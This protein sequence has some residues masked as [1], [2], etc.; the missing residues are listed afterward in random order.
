[1]KALYGFIVPLLLLFAAI[2][3]RVNDPAQVQQVR[4][5]VFDSYQRLDPRPYDPSLPVRI[6]D[7]DEESLD[8]FGQWPWSRAQ[9][10]LILDRLRELGAATVAIDVMMVEPDRT[11]PRA[12]A[13][14]LPQT[15]DFESARLLMGTLPDPDQQ[16]AEAMTRIPTILPFAMVWEDPRRLQARPASKAGFVYQ[17]NDET[18]DPERYMQ[19]LPYW[20]TSL[21]ILQE[22]AAGVGSVNTNPDNDGVTRHVPLFM[23]VP[24]LKPHPS[25][26]N[27][28]WYWRELP[29]RGSLAMEALR[30]AQGGTTYQI[31]MSGAN[32]ED[33]FGSD[34]GIAKVRVG[35]ITAPTASDG[36]LL[37]YD[38]GHKAERFFSLAD[39][40]DVDFDATQVTGRIIFI[41][42]SVQGLRDQ[43]PT[44]LDPVMAGVEIHA[45]IA[46]QLMAGQ[47]L[48]RPYWADVAEEATLVTFGLILIFLA[49]GRAAL[50]GLIVAT[51]AIVGSFGSSY[52]L[53]KSR[54][55]LLDP[56]YPAGI[57]FFIF[58]AATLIGFIRTER[59]KAHVR[60]AF[61]RY[62]SPILVDQLS[63]N[64]EK[65]KLGGELRELTVMFSDIRGFTKL[66]EGLD[67]Q[68]LTT[69]INSFLTPMTRVI[70]NRQG[71][72]DKYIGDCIMAFWNA[73]IDVEP[74]GRMAILA[75]YDMRAELVRI[76]Q[77]FA[78]EAAR[79]GDKLIEIRIGMG[80]NS[81]ICCVGNMGSDQRFDYSVLGDTVNTASRLESLSPAYFVDLVIGEETALTVPDFALLELDQVRVKG[82]N[83]PVRIYTGLG[84]ERVAK[85]NSFQALKGVHDAMLAAYRGQAWSA[86]RASLALAREAAPETLAKFYDMYEV[87]I[88]EYVAVP[89]PEDWDG[90]YVATTKGG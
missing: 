30:V 52:Y 5:L 80:L 71:T 4:N 36:S 74:H 2:V 37:L 33:F 42:T 84:D 66:S 47:Y 14:N 72:I 7:I 13:R 44:P 76:N 18:G 12:I 85:S 77:R 89:P 28:P 31:K 59:E 73:P 56:L 38:S 45:Q 64:P 82:K 55:F 8:K 53:F 87:R 63:K 19:R 43:K 86:A 16:L 3:L 22:V 11:S 17:R 39:I 90:V 88:A 50:F 15:A 26:R 51:V 49:Q 25:E 61:S 10:A 6:A 23:K 60:G 69:V 67:P 41:G 78:E 54:G 20:V 29:Y 83:V 27:D 58:V 81:G 68:R 79:T 75:A 40:W 35:Q 48:S 57:A 65:L 34:L 9:I 46:E 1:M 32:Q 21:D 70:Q 62:L 24:D